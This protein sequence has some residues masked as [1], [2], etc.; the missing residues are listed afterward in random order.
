MKR[1]IDNL[2]EVWEVRRLIARILIETHRE[3]R[4]QRKWQQVI[5]SM[6][7][8][9]AVLESGQPL[10]NHFSMRTYEET[11]AGFV[12]VSESHPF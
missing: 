5:A 9:A 7:H 1:P 8:M 12:L 6:K 3:V 2:R 10:Q 11:P 4:R